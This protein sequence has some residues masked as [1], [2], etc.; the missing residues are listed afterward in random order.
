MYT[1]MLSQ[2]AEGMEVY[3]SDGHR[4]GTV[5]AFRL[6]E[7][8]LKASRTNIV[9]IVEELAETMGKHKELPT[10]FYTRLYEEGFVRV[11]RGIL[12]SDV[13]IFSKQIEDI[14]ADAIY[15]NVEQGEL[16]HG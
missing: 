11:R 5:E 2:I 15:L 6:G 9:T 7:G 4:I 1:Q 13:L 10:A 12:R 14:Q 8:T 3:D 16:L